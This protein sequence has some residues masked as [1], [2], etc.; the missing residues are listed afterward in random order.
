MY[1]GSSSR[2]AEA[3]KLITGLNP[4]VFGLIEFRA[5]KQMRT[6]MLKHFKE[7]DFAVTDSKGGLEMIVGWRRGKFQQVI[8][9]QK[10]GFLNKNLGLRPGGLV[11]VVYGGEVY[12]LL[13]LHT[14]SGTDKKAYENRKA[15][16]KKIWKLQTAL[17]KNS[18]NN[19]ANLIAMG[20]LNTM[21][22]GRTISGQAEINKLKRDAE[23]NGMRML[24]KDKEYT[25]HQWGTGPRGRRKKLK[26]S[27]LADAKKSDLDHVIASKELSFY[28]L[29]GNN[30]EILVRGWNQLDGMDRINFLWDLSD[31]SA[32][33]GELA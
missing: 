21:G 9:T 16:F 17:K 27:E 23:K 13:Y 11:S 20:D 6:L 4:D 31:H 12:N 18:S 30:N 25:W 26:V 19:R 3:D 32:L 8:W 2:L 28:D 24:Y 5:K 22:K 33:Y 10:R 14:D 15:M 29:D 1:K 7:Y